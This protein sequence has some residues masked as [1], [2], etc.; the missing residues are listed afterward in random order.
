[1]H[2]NA[3]SYHVFIDNVFMMVLW[4]AWA[5]KGEVLPPESTEQSR[6]PEPH[7]RCLCQSQQCTGA[8]RCLMSP[9]CLEIVLR[10]GIF[11]DLLHS[12]SISLAKN[13]MPYSS[14]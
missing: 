11:R 10:Q 13:S 8:L 1:M 4:K 7:C 2:L 9:A 5:Q 3:L 12:A 6:N 14:D